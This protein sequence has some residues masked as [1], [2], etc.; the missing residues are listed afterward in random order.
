MKK[1]NPNKKYWLMKS[2]PSSYSIDT[3][4]KEKK[5]LWDGIRNYQARNFMMNEMSLGDE[6]LFYH[7]NAKPPGV[8]GIAKVSQP[9]Q[10]DPTARDP[11]SKYFDPKSTKENPIWHCVEIQFLKRLKRL[12]SLDEIRE[13]KKLQEMQLLKRSRLSIQP[14]TKFEFEYIYQISEK[15]PLNK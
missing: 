8:I 11:Q 7:S 15:T 3:F 2:E 12:V 14:L 6:V 5:T 13:E 9:A 10:P 1:I 4:K